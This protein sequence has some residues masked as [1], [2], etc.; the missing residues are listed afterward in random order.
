M[1]SALCKAGTYSI[2]CTLP[3]HKDAGMTAVLRVRE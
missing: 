3:G 1:R 2:L